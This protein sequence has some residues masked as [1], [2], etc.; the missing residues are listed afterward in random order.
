MTR[1]NRI[2]VGLPLYG[3]VS[4]TFLKHFF[5]FVSQIAAYDKYAGFIL[6]ERPYVDVA[7]N[8]I[9]QAALQEKGW[10]YLF[11]IEQDMTMPPGIL[12]R[13]GSLDP[14]THPIVGFLYFGKV[15]EDQRPIPGHMIDHRLKR[16]EYA[17]VSKMLPQRG[18]V[19]GLHRVDTVGMGATAI[20]RS[21]LE[22]WPWTPRHPWFRTDYDD[23]GVLGHDLWF[24]IEAAKLGYQVHT[25]SSLIP[26]HLGQWK[27][28]DETYLNTYELIASREKP[29]P[30]HLPG[31]VIPWVAGGLNAAT[32]DAVAASGLPSQLVEMRGQDDYHNLIADLWHD[33]ETFLTVEQDIVP[34]AGALE[35]MANCPEPWCAFAYEYPPFGHYAG[36]GCAK[37]SADLIKR[38]PDALSATGTWVDEKHPAKHWCRVDGWLKK[39]LMDHGQRQHIHGLVTHHHKGRPAHNCI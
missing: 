2:K 31:V 29:A 9:V 23:Y 34:A 24:C 19:A 5:A 27:S 39:Y 30:K 22:Q 25:D 38:F 7:M 37:F 28:T 18:G 17:E 33:G 26:G 11:S 10:D 3:T 32:V 16:L 4:A 35:E 36:M 14:A 12:E 21:V 6:N 1:R 15:A 13:I 8:E 20:H